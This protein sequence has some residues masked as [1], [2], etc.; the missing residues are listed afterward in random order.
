MRLHAAAFLIFLLLTA[1]VSF[2]LIAHFGGVIPGFSSTDEPFAALWDSWR[3]HSSFRGHLSLRST[4]LI[5]YP[6]AVDLFRWGGGLYIGT[7]WNHLLSLVLS[8]VVAWNLQIVLNFILCGFITYLLVFYLTGEWRAG[9]LSGVIFA[10]SPYQF[11]RAWQHLGL[12]YNQLIPLLLL[13]AFYYREHPTRKS[14]VFFVASGVLLASFDYSITYMGVVS[15]SVFLFYV[16]FYKWRIKLKQKEAL[17]A[18]PRYIRRMLLLIG[19]IGLIL[20]PQILPLIKNR[21]ALSGSTEASAFNAFHRP[22]EDLFQQSA[23]PLGYLL[24]AVHH[25]LFG[26]ITRNFVGSPLYGISLTEHTLYL[27]WTGLIL[28]FFAFRSW[29][30]R[31]KGDE[32][33]FFYAGFFLLL[34]F[35]AWLF[36]QPPWWQIG[37]MRISFPSRVMYKLLPMFRAYCRFGVVLMLSVAVLAGLQWSRLLRRVRSRSVGLALTVGICAVVL[38]EFWNWP[39]YKVIDVSRAP[40]AYTWLKAQP[41]TAVVAEYPLDVEAPN[42]MYKFYQ[43]FHG[44]KIINGALP[45]TPAFESVQNLARLSDPA[46]VRKLQ[47]RGVTYVVVHN[48]LYNATD[49]VS[50]EHELESIAENPLLELAAA[51]PGERCASQ[52][53][54]CVLEAEPIQIYTIRAQGD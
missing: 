44:K 27:G 47:E 46:T 13:A 25:P 20:L 45:G 1:I 40:Q 50:D 29:R 52:K 24:P 28:S 4:D 18:D 19:L 37:G 2:P 33:F 6:F 43:I 15:G 8:P 26:G 53:M 42:E 3:I 14:A 12:T 30:R 9:L 32:R 21:A 16:L 41:D 34:G 31:E 48:A 35:S 22:F 51:F 39:P 54:L 38:F 5:T 23:R 11:A 10:F 36:S 49:K 17:S 7:A